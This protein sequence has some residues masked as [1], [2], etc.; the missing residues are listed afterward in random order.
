[1]ILVSLNLYDNYLE[2]DGGV[3][4]VVMLKENCYIIELVRRVKIKIFER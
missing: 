3:V 4:I 1:M 2:G